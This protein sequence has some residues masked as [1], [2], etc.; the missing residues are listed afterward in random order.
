M[1]KTSH[2]QAMLYQAMP[3]KILTSQ[4]Y[5]VDVNADY[6]QLNIL[7]T[8]QTKQITLF[9]SHHHIIF[10]KIH[11]KYFPCMALVLNFEDISLY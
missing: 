6:Y 10:L 2:F 7:G 8:L 5:L 4:T 3:S 9:F 1:E 11:L